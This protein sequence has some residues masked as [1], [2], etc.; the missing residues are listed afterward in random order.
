MVKIDPLTL[1]LIAAILNG[2]SLAIGMIIGTRMTGNIF[3]KKLNKMINKSATAQRF[4]KLLEKADKIFGDDQAVEQVTRFFKEATDLVSSP[5]AK[6]FFK[7]MTEIMKG[8][9]RPKNPS[10]PPKPH[11]KKTEQTKKF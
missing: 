2:V 1:T 10:L 6:N 8:L 9:S 11:T 4:M 3:E 5:E 7:N